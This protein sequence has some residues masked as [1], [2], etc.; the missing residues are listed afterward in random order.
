M[1]LLCLQL[2][3]VLKRSQ[4]D[5]LKKIVPLLCD[6]ME[7]GLGLSLSFRGIIEGKVSIALL[8]LCLMIP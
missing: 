4:P 3:D 2:F 8:V 1:L 5:N 7:L 6:C